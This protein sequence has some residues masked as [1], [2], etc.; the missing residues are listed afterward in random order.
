ML[1]QHSFLHILQFSICLEI[2]NMFSTHP[3]IFNIVLNMHYSF[4]H[5]LKF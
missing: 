4:Q 5:A 3:E 2:F 1:F